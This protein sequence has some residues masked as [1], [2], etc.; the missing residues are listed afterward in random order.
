MKVAV[1]TNLCTHYRYK[2][3]K[4]LS[5]QYNFDFYFFGDLK[6]TKEDI[7]HLTVYRNNMSGFHY[8]SSKEIV[9]KLYKNKYDVII[10]CTNNKWL[11]FGCFL[12]AK[13]IKVKFIV[14]HTIWYHPETLQYKLFSNLFIRILKD[15]TDAI[16][17]Y[18]GHGKKFL[19]EKGINSEKIF[20]AWQTVDNELYGREIKEEEILAVRKRFEIPEDKKIVLYVG[21]LVELKGIEYLLEALNIL[22]KDK[23]LFIA[24]GDGKLKDF[25]KS[26]CENNNINFR[27]VGL[28]P[29][30]ELPVFYRIAR[31]L[32]LSSITTKRFKEPWGLV[33]NEAFNQRCPVIVT[34]AVGAG[35][36]GLVR[37]GLN[38]FVVPEKDAKSMANAINKIINDDKLYSTLSKNAKKEIVKWTYERQAKGFL[39]AVNYAENP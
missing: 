30:Y 31:V 19:I 15:Y 32:V 39:D 38:G 9:K 36:G 12:V 23:F 17:V 28:I 11:F 18:G 24:V 16:V 5:E 27:L 34:D 1:I 29:Y 14:W 2:L 10:K 35:I 7:K 8:M 4:L 25:I 33:V 6:K 26:Y 3:F 37:D 22:D 21:R 20:I 13:L